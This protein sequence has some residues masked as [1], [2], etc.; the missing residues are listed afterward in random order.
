MA[1]ILVKRYLGYVDTHQVS[2]M[3]SIALNTI[4]RCAKKYNVSIG[5]KFSSYLVINMK[6]EILKY[7]DEAR[8]VKYTYYYYNQKAQDHDFEALEEESYDMEQD[9]SDMPKFITID[10]I[11]NMLSEKDIGDNLLESYVYEETK[12]LIKQS[13][14]DYKII[15]YRILV[16][17]KLLECINN[18]SNNVNSQVEKIIIETIRQSIS[19]NVKYTVAQL[20]DRYNLSK[21]SAYSAHNEILK[22]IREC[23]REKMK[24]TP[25]LEEGIKQLLSSF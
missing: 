11:R 7:L 3:F 8:P 4:I 12:G 15:N 20:C 24:E 25:E 6:G 23:M 21:R 19:G 10:D 5:T 9:T 2:D 13:M 14:E 22:A 18:I 17:E 16:S 1:V